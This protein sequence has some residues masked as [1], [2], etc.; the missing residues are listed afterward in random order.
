MRLRVSLLACAALA[1][2]AMSAKAQFAPKPGPEHE[3][4]KK[5]AGDWDATVSVGGAESKGFSKNTL[6]LGG[7][8]LITEF[9]TTL[10]DMPFEGKGTTG[11]DFTKKKYVSS[12]VDSMTPSLMIGEGEFSKD[13][14]TYTELGEANGPDGKPMKMKSVYE[15]PN[16]DTM[17]FTMN[18]TA[19]DKDQ[20]MLK[21]TYHRKK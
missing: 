8:W 11:Y 16:D 14:K 21:I 13:G 1:L 9:K 17:I 20:E 10:G 5:F 4:L 18:T 12:W 3:K 2:S 15:W 19:G 7:Y 6:G